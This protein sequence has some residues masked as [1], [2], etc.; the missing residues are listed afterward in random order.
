[1]FFFLI[2]YIYIKKEGTLYFSFPAIGYPLLSW[3]ERR[4]DYFFR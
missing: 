3:Y 1:M 2:I 4:K